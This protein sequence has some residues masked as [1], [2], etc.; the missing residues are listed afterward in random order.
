MSS[1]IQCILFEFP[2]ASQNSK[3]KV[4]SEIEIPKYFKYNMQRANV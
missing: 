1:K 3:R 4:L 2:L